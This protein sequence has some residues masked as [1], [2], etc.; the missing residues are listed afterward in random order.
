MILVMI[1]HCR[2]AGFLRG[3]CCAYSSVD[4]H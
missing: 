1:K 2:K 3:L 4:A